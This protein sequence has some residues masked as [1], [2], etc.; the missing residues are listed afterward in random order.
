[1]AKESKEI[2]KTNEER[3]MDAFK[4]DVEMAKYRARVKNGEL[5]EEEKAD[6]KA[7]RDFLG[8]KD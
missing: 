2:K 4:A 1:M 6:R 5:T 3:E 8:Y 7:I